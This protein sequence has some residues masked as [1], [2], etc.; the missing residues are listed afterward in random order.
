MQGLGRERGCMGPRK[1]ISEEKINARLREVTADLRRL[2]R[3]LLEELR[4]HRRRPRLAAEEGPRR[5]FL[6]P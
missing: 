3:D 5:H 1:E 2:R 4:S 6:E